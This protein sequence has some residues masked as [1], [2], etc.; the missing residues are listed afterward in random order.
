M[1]G[2]EGSKASSSSRFDQI[3]A[4]R[5][6]IDV[7]QVAGNASDDIKRFLDPTLIYLSSERAKTSF[8]APIT[9]RIRLSEVSIVKKAEEPTKEEGRVVCLLT[10]GEGKTQLLFSPPICLW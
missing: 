4:A 3:A 8:G 9:Q 10:V 2:K 1:S 7:S 5:K 6:G